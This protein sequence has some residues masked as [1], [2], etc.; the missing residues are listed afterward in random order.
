MKWLYVD[1]Q[2]CD[3][4]LLLNRMYELYLMKLTSGE[5]DIAMLNERSRSRCY[6]SVN[7]QA[8]FCLQF[9]VRQHFCA[10]LNLSRTT[11]S[12]RGSK[13]SRQLGNLIFSTHRPFNF[14]TNRVYSPLYET[15]CPKWHTY[16]GIF[17]TT[18]SLWAA[19]VERFFLHVQSN[20][21]II[22]DLPLPPHL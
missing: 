16:S 22:F 7:G 6:V 1:N 15:I 5:N 14:Y 4:I 19:Q 21:F 11:K 20:G 8:Y 17:F 13:R 12:W 2:A 3:D 9:S 10:F 18:Q